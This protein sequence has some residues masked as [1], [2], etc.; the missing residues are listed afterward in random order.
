MNSLEWYKKE[1]NSL[2][3]QYE[4]KKIT[5]LEFSDR[6]RDIECIAQEL[7]QDDIKSAIIKDC[8]TESTSAASSYAD[9]YKEGYN[10]ALGLIKSN[11][12]NQLTK[13]NE[14]PKT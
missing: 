5:I 10:R 13:N 11:I 6:Y 3:I 12:E 9:G 1:L 8:A 7:Y 2:M 14:L 4:T